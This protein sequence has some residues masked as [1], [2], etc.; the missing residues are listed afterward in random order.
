MNR[1]GRPVQQNTQSPSQTPGNQSAPAKNAGPKNIDKNKLTRIAY[2]AFISLLGLL[3]LGVLTSMLL[4]KDG[5]NSEASYVDTSKHQA[6][7]LNGGQ[8]YF[9]KVTDLNSKFLNL[10]DIYYLR[11]NQQVQP[12]QG[13]NNNAAND[14]SLVKLGC[15]LH[16]PQDAMVIN[17]EQVIF[18]ENLK[19]DGQVAKAIEEF[20][21]ANPD[22]QKCETPSNNGNNTNTNR[23]NNGNGDVAPAN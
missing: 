22:G 10:N 18:W 20:V 15:E 9:G 17:R 5:K 21:K 19:N 14:I 7:F 6:V 13:Q 23:E 16:G 11:V 4:H 2:V 3:L 1:G 12:E 8:V